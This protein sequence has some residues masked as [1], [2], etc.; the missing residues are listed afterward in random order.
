MPK[1]GSVCRSLPYD[2]RELV[3]DL[4]ET[5]L[6]LAELADRV[7]GEV[8]FTGEGARLF[9]ADIERLLPGERTLRHSLLRSRLRERR[10][11]RAGYDQCRPAG[12]SR[13][14]VA[15]VYP[16]T[17]GRTGMEKRQRSR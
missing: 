1:E 10:R 6:P 3:Q 8:L 17:G 12:R 4:P 16:Q 2:G 5:V 11:D 15:D 13:W 14:P 9:A 7:A